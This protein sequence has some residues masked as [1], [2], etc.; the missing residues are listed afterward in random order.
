MGKS[1]WIGKRVQIVRAEGQTFAGLPCRD[2]HPEH[3]SKKGT[4]VA[5]DTDD[6]WSSPKIE[7]DE[8]SVI[9]GYECWWKPL[10]WNTKEE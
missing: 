3:I 5:L 2:P 1:W 9:W 4:I 10:G 8:G 6:D 7:L